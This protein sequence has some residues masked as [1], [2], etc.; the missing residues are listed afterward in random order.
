MGY[1]TPMCTH[2]H[3]KTHTERRAHKMLS[4]QLMQLWCQCQAEHIFFFII[5]L[6]PFSSFLTSIL[7]FFSIAIFILIFARCRCKTRRHT[8]TPTYPMI[9]SFFFFY[10]YY[11]YC[12]AVFAIDRQACHCNTRQLL[13]EPA[14]ENCR[15]DANGKH[16]PLFTCARG[17]D[18]F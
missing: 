1:R 13:R 2:T 3:T 5:S 14:S 6:L 12:H 16:A 7:L 4:T 17:C 9:G 11:F 8:Q 10:Y 15:S 18:A